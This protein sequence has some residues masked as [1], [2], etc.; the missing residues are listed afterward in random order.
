MGAGM[1]HEGRNLNRDHYTVCDVSHSL[2]VGL[3]ER[4]HYSKSCG[5]VAVYRHGLFDLFGVL[6]GVAVWL[7]PTR[8]AA[9]KALPESPQDVLA[10]SRLAIMPHVPRNGATFLMGRSIRMIRA[11]GRWKMLLT[12]ADTWQGHDGTIYRAANWTEAGQSRPTD[13][14][15]DATGKML[16][17]KRG[18]KNLSVAEMNAA[19]FRKIGKFPKI[20]FTY[21]LRRNT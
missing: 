5:K 4:E 19:G 14:W 17:A 6:C 9:V 8:A 2:A 15:T 21:D 7:P 3:V 1:K 20:R 16:G 10:L 12:F 11:A 18:P 13:V